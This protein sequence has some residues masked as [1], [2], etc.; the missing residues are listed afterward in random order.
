MVLREAGSDF[1]LSSGSFV[2]SYNCKDS[3]LFLVGLA[4]LIVISVLRKSVPLSRGQRRS[5][6]LPPCS[7]D[8]ELLYGTYVLI[9][10]LFLPFS[11]YQKKQCTVSF[12]QPTY[13]TTP[14][15]FNTLVLLH[16]IPSLQVVSKFGRRTRVTTMTRFTIMTRP[17]TIVHAFTAGSG[18]WNPRL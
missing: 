13:T 7:H 11:Y 15:C 2:M 16:T 5:T 17:I 18:S 12:T 1:I 6:C 9:V 4:A 3:G 8:G 14:K 10:D